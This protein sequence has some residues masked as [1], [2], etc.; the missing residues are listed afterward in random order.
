MRKQYLC[1]VIL[2]ILIINLLFNPFFNLVYVKDKTTVGINLG[3]VQ[4]VQDISSYV[5]TGQE[6][7]YFIVE[8]MNTFG[9]NFVDVQ[10]LL[11][12]TDDYGV[13]VVPIKI[14]NKSDKELYSVECRSIKGLG[15]GIWLN[16]TSLCDGVLDIEGREP[17]EAQLWF[18]YNKK[19]VKK[20]DIENLL[21]KGKIGIFFQFKIGEMG[22]TG[23]NILSKKHYTV[24]K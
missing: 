8:E 4:M 15:K 23:D 24:A 5:H 3:K 9:M 12:N 21:K 10:M 11:H 20:E 18:I 2:V 19:S 17:V 22:G 13:A 6:E 7:K 1:I 14:E 16:K